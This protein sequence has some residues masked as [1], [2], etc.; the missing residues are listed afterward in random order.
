MRKLIVF[1]KLRLKILFTLSN[2]L[3]VDTQL[4]LSCIIKKMRIM[5]L[6][7][8]SKTIVTRSTGKSETLTTNFYYLYF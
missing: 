3:L 6:P 1:L 8:L 7:D 4:N 2:G 5:R